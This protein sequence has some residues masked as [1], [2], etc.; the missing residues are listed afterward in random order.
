MLCK[1]TTPL[2]LLLLEKGITYDKERRKG[3]AYMLV[4][5]GLDLGYFDANEAHDKFIINEKA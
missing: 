1:E 5:N 3:T 4:K 2:N